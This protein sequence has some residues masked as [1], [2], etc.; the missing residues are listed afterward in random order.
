MSEI[1]STPTLKRLKGEFKWDDMTR[2]PGI[3]KP[4]QRIPILWISPRSSDDK[5]ITDYVLIN[6][7]GES[8]E[9]VTI[10]IGGFATVDDDPEVVMNLS[11]SERTYTDVEPDVAVL[12]AQYDEMYD[13][14]F[15]LQLNVS[16]VS[17]SLGKLSFAL[18]KKGGFGTVP[19][20]YADGDSKYM[21]K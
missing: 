13:S 9:L 17:K 4:D 19:L 6:H 11:E 3:P 5:F 10:D 14:D 20:L 15:V 1:K 8:L 16:I 21:I 18:S 7:T 12:I 2:F